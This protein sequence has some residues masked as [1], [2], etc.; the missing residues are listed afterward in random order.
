MICLMICAICNDPTLHYFDKVSRLNCTA[1]LHISDIDIL[2]IVIIVYICVQPPQLI[3]H[4]CN[5]VREQTIIQYLR[6]YYY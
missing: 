6:D 4:K 1:I 2:Y 3:P 5:V